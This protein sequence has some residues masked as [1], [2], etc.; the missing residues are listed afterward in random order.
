MT[1]RSFTKTAA[2]GAAAFAILP[3]R[4]PAHSPRKGRMEFAV[5]G[6]THDH[7]FR[8]TQA[9]REGGGELAMIYAPEPDPIHGTRFLKENPDV[10]RAREER[11]VLESPDIKLV[12]TA[13]IPVDR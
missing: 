8:M 2:A 11:E 4:S 1:R 5:R 6:A 10:P 13:A 7:I 3:V 9:V 12:V